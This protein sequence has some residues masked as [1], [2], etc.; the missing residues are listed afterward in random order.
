MDFDYE[1]E[2]FHSVDAW[3]M[4]LNVRFCLGMSRL[5]LPL[6]LPCTLSALV[7]CLRRVGLRNATWIKLVH[8]VVRMTS[9]GRS[10]EVKEERLERT[11]R[12]E[13]DVKSDA[14]CNTEE[15]Q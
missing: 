1:K 8:D 4:M 2:S 6:K 9:R 3:A 10:E 11:K 7:V 13:V 12:R 15:R 14:M 5:K